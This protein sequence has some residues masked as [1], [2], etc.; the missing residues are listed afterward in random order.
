MRK[1]RSTMPYTPRK[2]KIHQT[3][4]RI[5]SQQ[6]VVIPIDRFAWLTDGVVRDIEKGLPLIT[7]SKLSRDFVNP[8]Q[9]SVQLEQQ[10]SNLYEGFIDPD[11][12]DYELPPENDSE[13]VDT[14]EQH[15][16]RKLYT[17]LMHR[18]ERKTINPGTGLVKRPP[19]EDI[20]D[21][22][23]KI[24]IQS[25]H[26]RKYVPSGR[27]P[28]PPPAHRPKTH[29]LPDERTTSALLKTHLKKAFKVGVQPFTSVD[30]DE[31]FPLNGI[32]NS[33]NS[34]TSQISFNSIENKN[35]YENQINLIKNKTSPNFDK[36]IE[37]NENAD[38]KEEEEEDYDE[39]NHKSLLIDP[40]DYDIFW[41]RNGTPFTRDEVEMLEGWKEDVRDRM[42]KDDMKT[43]Q[44]LRRREK[45]MERT[46]QS[47]SAF[48]KEIALTDEAMERA[49]TLGPCKSNRERLSSWEVSSKAVKDDPSSLP[50]RK[51]TWAN[52]V[53]QFQDLYQITCEPQKKIVVEFRTL[54]RS[55]H[56]V[57]ADLFFDSI[58]V[59]NKM[60][61]ISMPTM[62]LVEFL[63]KNLNVPE[64][65][66]VQYM[67]D[68]GFPHQFYLLAL[69][70]IEIEE[71]KKKG[72][73]FT[74]M[75]SR[76]KKQAAIYR[77]RK[78]HSASP[79]S[80]KP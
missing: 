16:Y 33:I 77:A 59:L 19:A 71:N 73:S 9:L 20:I 17:K 57:D 10:R 1:G 5:T 22:I 60:D 58:G 29:K 28:F 11:S 2:I 52:F 53:S 13:V 43:L 7:E 39:K 76:N 67:K 46:F 61:Y 75:T 26:T 38:N 74:I 41:T 14:E 23:G 25:V 64:D 51:R 18:R 42:V 8:D 70:E 63:R 40:K 62:I 65:D 79:K 12:N 56:C 31:D 50:F 49:V 27:N 35:Q 72:D 45:A 68:N 30:R 34:V 55:G 36:K 6:G 48:D 69:D 37:L 3:S 54:L 24:N 44:I 32:F 15:Q 66:V 80:V 78:E 47:R 4:R 21:N